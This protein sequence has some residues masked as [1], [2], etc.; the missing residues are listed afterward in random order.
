MRSIHS[1][2]LFSALQTAVYQRKKNTSTATA[3][4]PQQTSLRRDTAAIV[5]EN[6]VQGGTSQDPSA[7]DVTHRRNTGLPNESVINGQAVQRALHGKAHVVP[8]ATQELKIAAHSEMK[9]TASKPSFL[10]DNPRWMN[11]KKLLEDLTHTFSGKYVWP[12][13]QSSRAIS[14]ECRVKNENEKGIRQGTEGGICAGFSAVW[15]ERKAR[16]DSLENYLTPGH[17]TDLSQDA[18][19]YN[20]PPKRAEKFFAALDARKEKNIL[21]NK[22]SSAATVDLNK[23][24]YV[25]QLS[26][27]GTT[28]PSDAMIEK[29]L[30]GDINQVS[31]K[32][33][34]AKDRKAMFKYQDRKQEFA[35]ANQR[36]SVTNWLVGKNFTKLQTVAPYQDSALDISNTPK[37]SGRDYAN[38]MAMKLVEDEMPNALGDHI[39]RCIDIRAYD[40]VEHSKEMI[41]GF[42][43]MMAAMVSRSGAVAFFDPNFGEFHFNSKNDFVQWWP[44]FLEAAKYRRSAEEDYKIVSFASPN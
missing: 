26:L 34:S 38:K 4:S 3:A 22:E 23:V 43:H 11:K 33:R 36:A 13:S 10:A 16:G 28:L 18:R 41:N 7:S 5:K 29:N 9:A 1:S 14:A 12:F 31:L 40:E 35:A 44:E 25:M 30:W 24:R 20:P 8:L 37:V 19:V 21:E 15:L 6:T 2:G 39:Y 17:L 27:L 32:G 42:G